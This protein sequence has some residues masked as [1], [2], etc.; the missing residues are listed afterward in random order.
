MFLNFYDILVI[1]DGMKKRYFIIVLFCF[2]FLIR[3]VLGIHVVGIGDSIT[4]GFG[5]KEEESYLQ[6]FCKLLEE[7]ERE[8]VTFQNLAIDGLTSKQ[9]AMR[10][11]DERFQTEIKKADYLL[12]SIGGNDF[13]KEFATHLSTYLISADDYPHMKEIQAELLDNIKQ[14]YEQLYLLNPEMEVFVVPLYNPYY[15]YLKN[16]EVLIQKFQDAKKAYT[17]LSN[18]QNHVVIV[19]SLSDILE[20]PDYS[21][22]TS[23]DRM[24]D[25]HPNALGHAHIASAFIELVKTESVVKEE[26]VLGQTFPYIYFVVSIVVGIIAVIWYRKRK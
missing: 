25:P 22:V 10:L 4:S 14:I 15:K 13:L 12:M 3:P 8:S 16:N 6:V 20:N 23:S 21:N 18:K 1:G 19:P 26:K 5:V 11:K 2:F 24:F 17:T 9:L 7:R